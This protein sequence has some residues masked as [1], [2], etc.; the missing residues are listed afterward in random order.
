MNHKR[1]RR[2]GMT[3]IEILVVLVIMSAIASAVGFAVVKNLERSRIQDTKTRART[4]QA[5]VAAYLM[6][7][8]GKCPNVDDLVRADI[9]DSTTDHRDAWGRPFVIECEGTTIHVKSTGSDGQPGTV[10]DLGF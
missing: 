3:L 1:R 5:A 6:D 10:D 2:A 7:N 8:I 4:I 9:L